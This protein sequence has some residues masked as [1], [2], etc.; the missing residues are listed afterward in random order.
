MMRRLLPGIVVFVGVLAL[1]SCVCE[2]CDHGTTNKELVA[3]AFEI[4]EAGDLDKLDDYVAPDYV[5]HC[6]ATPELEVTSLEGFKEYL[7][8]DRESVPNPT[9]TVH[10]LI[11]EDDLVAF[12]ATYSGVQ[13][14]PMGPFPA[15]GNRLELDFAGMHRIEDG[16]I[17]ETWITWDNMTALDQLGLLPPMPGE[18]EEVV[19]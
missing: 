8:R 16:K 6:Q 12:W 10:R 5:R 2:E 7:R 4:V 17:A 3:E 15:T 9:L 19:E 14:G 11:G 13:E 18:V 1:A